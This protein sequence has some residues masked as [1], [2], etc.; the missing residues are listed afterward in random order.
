GNDKKEIRVRVKPTTRLSAVV[1]MYK[2]ITKVT[3]NVQLYFEGESL[4]LNT[5]IDDTELEDEDL[6]DVGIKNE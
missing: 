5:T 6:L 3:G 1:E 4:E 2:K